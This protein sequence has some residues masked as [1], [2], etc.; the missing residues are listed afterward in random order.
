[1]KT[2][3]NRSLIQSIT[4]SPWVIGFK[5]V[6]C[7]R[8]DCSRWLT[9]RHLAARRVGVTMQDQWYCSYSCFASVASER[10][11]RLLSTT[12]ATSAR[13]SRMPLSL[14]LMSR[15]LLTQE[16]AKQAS[17][18]QEKIGADIGDILIQLGYVDEKDVTAARSS[19]WDCPVF[20]S[21]TRPL[22]LSTCQADVPLTFSRM[23]SM[24]PL[25]Y[26]HSTNTLMLGFVYGVEYAVLYSIEQMTGCRTRACLITPND[27]ALHMQ[28]HA[29]QPPPN[30]LTFETIQAPAKM[31]HTLCSYG[32]LLNANE[33]AIGRCREY[34]WARM[35][36]PSGTSNIL[37][38]T[39]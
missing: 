28:Y 9:Q 22:H 26:I 36:T 7:S 30:D 16:Q 33:V 12:P 10:L 19:Q 24:I 13:I 35:K 39:L 8:D 1:M 38:R 5:T 4:A 2:A 18:E 29:H 20:S 23:H 6:Q 27:F 11:T 32:A 3:E 25:H 31:A 14:I 34:L 37:F 21:S 15:G 17:I